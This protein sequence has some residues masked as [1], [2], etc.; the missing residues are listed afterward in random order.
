MNAISIRTATPDDAAAI[1]AVSTASYEHHFPA[2]YDAEILRSVLPIITKAS[3]V[4]LQSG[5]FL[6][7]EAEDGAVIGCGGWSEER[8]GTRETDGETAH[9]RHFA[10]IPGM[11]GRG[12]GRR[13]FEA[14]HAQAQS[15]GL[16]RLVVWSSLHA[17]P[18]YAR[19]GFVETGPRTA[20]IAGTLPFPSIEMHKNI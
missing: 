20:M 5:R 15:A 6:V 14:C 12:V 17:T 8:P 18:F 2:A 19:L 13:I 4:L 10:V 16:I 1:Q 9:L 11:G 7:A 3:P